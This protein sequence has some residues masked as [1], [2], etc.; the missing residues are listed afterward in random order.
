MRRRL[1]EEGATIENDA[2]CNDDVDVAAMNAHVDDDDVNNDV[3]ESPASNMGCDLVHA[4]VLPKQSLLSGG[5]NLA[6]QALNYI[7]HPDDNNAGD[8]V[9]PPIAVV[10][11][12]EDPIVEWDEND[13]L[14][15]AV[16]ASLFLLGK[17]LSKGSLNKKSL[18]HLFL[19]YDGRFEDPLFIATAFN[20]LQRH[21]CVRQTA[22]IGAK[23]ASQLQ[24]L[25]ELANSSAFRQCL[26]WAHDNPLSD[27]AKKLNAKRERGA[28]LNIAT[29]SGVIEPQKGGRLH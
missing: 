10:S 11:R 27:E 7:I 13:V 21:T 16:F 17:G 12:G 15:S 25:G 2:I 14:M 28:Y 23:R 6:L 1:D 22:R 8:R 20:Q 9:P 5:V 26:L 29:V 18:R 24:K 4:A 3:P 19:Y